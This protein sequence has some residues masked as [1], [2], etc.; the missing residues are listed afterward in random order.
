M[1]MSKMLMPTA[2]IAMMCLLFT[3]CKNNNRQPQNSQQYDV[4]ELAARH[5]RIYED[6]PATLEGR[7]VVEI[8]TK[9]EGYLEELYVDEGAYVTK[10]QILFRISS[11]QYEQE[12][13]SA[14]AGI[15]T[16][17]AEVDA[18]EMDVRKT[19]PLVEKDIISKYQLESAE[20][21]LKTKKAAL[22]Q[23]KATLTNAKANIGYTIISSPANGFINSIPY[24]KGSLVSS[25]SENPLTTLSNDNEVYAYFAMNEKQLLNFNRRFKGY[26][27]QEKLEN[28]PPVQLILADGSLF[29]PTGKIETAS[30]LIET[31]TGSVNFRAVFSNKDGLL[32]SGGSAS[33]RIPIE[34]DSA[35]VIPQS[36]TYELQNKQMVYT[37]GT[38]NKAISKNITVTPSN[39]GQ[40]FIINSGLSGGDK[41][42][43][44]GLTS[45]KDSLVIQPH[46]VTPQSVFKNIE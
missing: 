38:G 24:K 41:V 2:L 27:I 3:T 11:P 46:E 33:V 12:L 19:R 37:L 17:Q 9:V 42:I 16:A 29:E 4:L 30:G 45:L 5:I 34:M 40:F 15:L 23:A 7:E 18:A 35:L 28:L 10:G 6:Y 25:S 22:E 26:T 32:K 14:Q 8:R 20:Y 1:K 31:A 43:L 36:A 13:R 21:A 44:S 39:D